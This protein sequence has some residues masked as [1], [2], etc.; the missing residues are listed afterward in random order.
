MLRVPYRWVQYAVHEIGVLSRLCSQS[1]NI[2]SD[3]RLSVGHFCLTGDLNNLLTRMST[4]FRVCN[5]KRYYF[6][7]ITR[8]RGR[9]E[10]FFH[11]VVIVFFSRIW[12]SVQCLPLPHCTCIPHLRIFSVP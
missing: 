2:R 6:V 1:P 10:E 5:R 7:L 8:I 11:V 4:L 9:R 3:L 12:L